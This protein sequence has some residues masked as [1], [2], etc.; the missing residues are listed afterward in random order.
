MTHYSVCNKRELS[1]LNIKT[2][3]AVCS[4]NAVNLFSF[5]F[6]LFY[7]IYCSKSFDLFIL[8]N[9]LFVC[10]EVNGPFNPMGSCRARHFI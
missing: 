2:Y 4:N 8:N 3:H 5:L 9:Y 10:V 6:F 1:Y 7:L